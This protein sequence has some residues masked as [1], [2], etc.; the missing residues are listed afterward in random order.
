MDI[1]KKAN[2]SLKESI[3]AG[4]A[5]EVVKNYAGQ[6]LN[7]TGALIA[8]KEEVDEQGEVTT[9]KIGVLKGDDKLIS[10]ISN[11]VINSIDTY[12]NSL[13]EEEFKKGI[14]VKV[15]SS[16]SAKGREFF[17]LELE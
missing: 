2:M 4:N 13:G 6:T 3:N 14:P 16:K 5:V 1:L 12:I 8:L 7:V 10:S 15:C 9:T 17:F 11:T